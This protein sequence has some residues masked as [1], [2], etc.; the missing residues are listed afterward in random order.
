VSTDPP[1]NSSEPADGSVERRPAPDAR[2]DPVAIKQGAI[3]CLAFAVPFTLIARI[4]LD[5]NDA[6]GWAAVLGLASFVGFVVGGGVSAWI[7]RCGTPLSHGVVT[8]AGV[9]IVA[10]FAF[11]VVRLLRGDGV[12]L[13]RILV[14]LTLTV[15]AGLVGG[16]LGS[17]LQRQGVRPSR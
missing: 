6:S 7:Q 12:N 11:S 5:E 9:F 16:F 4:V 2:W 14:S 10:Q 3:T 15:G 1:V 17:Y 13:G 8:S